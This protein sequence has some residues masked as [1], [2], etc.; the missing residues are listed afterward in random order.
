MKAKETSERNFEDAVTTLQTDDE[1]RIKRLLGM[2]G[3]AK[4]AGKTLGGTDMICGEIRNSAEAVGD[5]RVRK[6]NQKNIRLVLIA[7]DISQNTLKRIGNC[8]G[9]YGVRCIKL[10]IGTEELAH[11]VGKN[12]RSG[13]GAVGRTA[14]VGITDENFVTAIE[15]I[16]D[17]GCAEAE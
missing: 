5:T 17:E 13:S 3:L 4:R 16:L 9:F 12:K 10:P 15:K 1:Q 14:A 11:V 2:I 8:C 6:D 7:S